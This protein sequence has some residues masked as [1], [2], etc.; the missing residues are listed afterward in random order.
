LNAES[1]A[2]QPEYKNIFILESRAWWP[3]CRNR[4]DPR[5]D[6]VLTYDFGL[7]R[8]VQRIGG[9]ALY[10]DH[11]VDAEC[12]QQ[13]NFLTYEFL[14]NWHLDANGR[15]IFVFREIVFGFSFRLEIWN[16]LVFLARTRL[17]VEKVRQ[18]RCA[19]LLVGTQGGLIESMLNELGVPFESIKCIEASDKPA[20]YFPIHQWMDEKVRSRKFRHKLKPFVASVMGG[21]R[22]WLTCFSRSEAR[23]PAVFVQEYYPTRQIVEHLQRDTRLRVVLAQYS[24]APGLAKFVREHP[25]PVRGALDKY[26]LQADILLTRFRAAHC[27]QLIL[28]G[29]LDITTRIGEVIEKRVAAALPETLR[30]LDC[31]ISYLDTNPIRLEVMISNLG[32]TNTLI[33]CICKHRGIRSYMIVNG[34]MVHAYLDEAKYADT[35]NA[36]SR[37]MKENYFRRSTNIVSLGD[38]RMDDYACVAPRSINRKT[39]TVTIG[40]SGHNITNLDSYVAV[41]FDF[42]Y[43]VLHA[44][45]V[46]RERGVELRVIIKV[47]SNGYWHQYQEFAEEYFPGLVDEILQAVPMRSVL[48]RTD[49][50]ISIYSQTLFEASCLGIP[51]LYYKKDTETMFAPF[52]GKSELV[53]VDNVED[54]IAACTDFLAGHPRFDAF[55]QRPIMEKYIGFLDGGNLARN[56]QYIYELLQIPRAAGETA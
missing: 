51:C 52:D 19:A 21:I 45:R 28:T 26:R 7:R 5:A 47:R 2:R 54:L 37:S 39:P 33:D 48:D 31:A 27:A 24:W 43:D 29:G 53:T 11:L 1:G 34:M 38:P 56:L 18:M 46:V 16:D 6:L 23:K 4:F 40:A 22:Y 3:N 8:E 20:Y 12:M 30:T 13:N 36:Y 55:L 10:F 9:A 41:E 14:R 15:D 35:I 44:L 42:L 49:F 25:I 50:Y 17:C 32:R